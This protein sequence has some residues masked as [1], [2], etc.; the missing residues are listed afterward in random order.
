M[1]VAP[2]PAAPTDV[3]PASL[4]WITILSISD[5][6]L[7]H[8][9]GLSSVAA[10]GILT[11]VK[12]VAGLFSGSLALL[13][14]AAHGAVDTGATLVTFFAVRQSGKP[15]DEDHHFG[16]EK[17]EALAALFEVFLLFDV[18]L[19]VVVEA[20]RRLSSGHTGVELS[21]WVFGALLLSIGVD[22][23]RWRS[24][25]HIARRTGSD[26]LAAD[27]VHFS[28]DLFASLVVLAGLGAY[29]AGWR[30]ADAYASFGVAALIL[31]A[32]IRLAFQTVGTLLD[33]A[34][35]GIAPRLR[36]VA[37]AVPGVTDVEDLRLRRLG[38]RS[39]GNMTIG[40]PRSLP[41]ERVD[42][43]AQAVVRRLNRAEPGTDVVV[44]AVPRVLNDETL[45][46]RVLLVAARRRQAVHHITVQH[47]DGRTSISF[48]LE[49]DGAM[50]HGKA[51]EI[52]TALE[53]AIRSEIGPDIEVESHIE[54]LSV[55]VLEGQ[56]ESPERTSAIAQSLTEAA[57]RGGVVF[58]IHDVRVRRTIDGLVVNYHCRIDPD[59][60]VGAVHDCVDVMEH[61]VRVA[62]PLI[63]RLVGH[64]EP[65]R[66][67]G[68]DVG[69]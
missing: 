31:F 19:V 32:A 7:K 53:A 34:P 16:H 24:L 58:D 61:S 57:V 54:P 1:R 23:V 21:A 66:T 40:V 36:E 20:T 11:L 26:A 18:A 68:S 12:L 14:E 3:G 33:K 10:S 55:G 35:E 47:V 38:G 64:A 67:L 9:A 60:S 37:L 59:L 43:V 52:A 56:D 42:A 45:L 49:V 25:S 17:V 29:A 2:T 6:D 27:A 63:V 4:H 48:D 46:E 30:Q 62:D 69:L 50:P 51:H 39:V 8:R 22:F 65:P 13:S 5:H 44:A 15:A 28:S 41:S